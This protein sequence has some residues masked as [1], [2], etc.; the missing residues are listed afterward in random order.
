[1]G[2]PA[3]KAGFLFF[4]LVGNLVVQKPFIHFHFFIWWCIIIEKWGIVDNYGDKIGC[5]GITALFK[6]SNKMKNFDKKA[7]LPRYLC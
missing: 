2:K 7:M 1:L 3:E 4:G 6:I 5:L